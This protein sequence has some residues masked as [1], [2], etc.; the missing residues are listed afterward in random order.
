LNVSSTGGA[1]AAT[2]FGQNA[3]KAG[4]A[5]E[6]L[7]CTGKFI[8]WPLAMSF[9][10]IVNRRFSAV[11]VVIEHIWL[12]RSGCPPRHRTSEEWRQ[13]IGSFLVGLPAVSATDPVWIAGLAPRRKRQHSRYSHTGS[14]RCVSGFDA[15]VAIHGHFFQTLIYLVAF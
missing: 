13:L 8:Y 1:W 5:R 9:I 3:R 12:M 11:A 7:Q 14:K 10:M 6:G 2:V 4:G 15:H